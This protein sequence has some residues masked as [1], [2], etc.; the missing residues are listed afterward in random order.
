MKTFLW[1]LCLR[2]N[3]S[4]F[5]TRI[6]NDSIMSHSSNNG[7]DCLLERETIRFIFLLIGEIWTTLDSGKNQLNNCLSCLECLKHCLIVSPNCLNDSTFH[8]VV[9]DRL[10]GMHGFETT[11][12]LKKKFT[13]I[14]SI[15]TCK[16]IELESP[17][18]PQIKDS[19]KGFP[20]VIYFLMILAQSYSHSCL[21]RT[22]DGWP[23]IWFCLIRPWL[24]RY[25]LR[26]KKGISL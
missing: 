6:F 21:S 15:I 11:R 18:T 19:F 22:Q 10:I 24:E 7:S 13:W 3:R 5:K 23:P 12:G 4:F 16:R 17:A 20:N 26:H 2:L 25:G 8:S 1:H 14:C 9:S